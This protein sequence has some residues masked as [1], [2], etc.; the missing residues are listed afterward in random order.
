MGSNPGVPTKENIWVDGVN[1]SMLVS[2]TKGLCSNRSRPANKKK[3][4]IFT[5][6]LLNN[7]IELYILQCWEFNFPFDCPV[8]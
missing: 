1:G 8:V 6:F 7:C 3:Y 5:E 4:N 2:K